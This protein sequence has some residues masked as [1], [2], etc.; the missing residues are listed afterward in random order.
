[1]SC[2]RSWPSTKRFTAVPPDFHPGSEYQIRRFH[3]AWTRSG[4]IPGCG[5]TFYE[6]ARG[7]AAE[8]FGV[9]LFLHQDLVDGTGGAGAA[10]PE[11]GADLVV[12]AA[13]GEAFEHLGR[14]RAGRENAGYDIIIEM[15]ANL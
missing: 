7:L 9:G 12:G 2:S 13:P 14:A 8:L 11:L 15:A 3:T 1:M 5:L 10:V 6:F 4:R